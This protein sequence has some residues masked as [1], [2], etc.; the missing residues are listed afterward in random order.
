MDYSLLLFLCS[1]LFG[2]FNTATP[3]LCSI[4]LSFSP[5]SLEDDSPLNDNFSFRTEDLKDSHTSKK[6]SEI[7]EPDSSGDPELTPG[8]LNS[9]SESPELTASVETVVLDE[10]PDDDFISEKDYSDALDSEDDQTDSLSKDAVDDD[11]GQHGRLF[12]KLSTEYSDDFKKSTEEGIDMDS[13]KTYTVRSVL[14][15]DSLLV[16]TTPSGCSLLDFTGEDD[17]F[18]V[19]EFNFKTSE[20]EECSKLTEDIIREMNE[21]LARDLVAHR[22][23][24][25]TPQTKMVEIS[26]RDPMRN[27]QLNIKETQAV[28]TASDRLNSENSPDPS[29]PRFGDES[30]ITEEDRREALLLL[31]RTLDFDYYPTDSDSVYVMSFSLNDRDTLDSNREQL[32]NQFYQLFNTPVDQSVNEEESSA[33]T[34][35]KESTSTEDKMNFESI[36]KNLSSY[37]E[38]KLEKL[39]DEMKAFLETDEGKKAVE[40]FQNEMA[41]KLKE[42]E[43]LYKEESELGKK[44]LGDLSKHGVENVQCSKLT[45]ED[46]ANYSKC[47]VLS[48]EG[49][50]V[51]FVSPKTIYWLMQ[52]KCGLQS[53]AALL[54]IARDLSNIGIISNKHVNNL[55]Q[56]FDLNKICNA[57]THSYLS[58][59]SPGLMNP[60]SRSANSNN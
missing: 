52:T 11:E 29:S 48:V 24:Q 17:G 37:S 14:P 28:F 51:C 40:K 43:K 42:V 20:L 35:N 30:D 39:L 41:S 56:S 58:K 1:V 54:S 3:A 5:D 19:V 26:V 9:R 32:L 38:E 34:E 49:K 47:Q 15:V 57:I 12:E 31:S 55:E 25:A 59:L 18:Q 36:F 2:I 23:T 21:Q 13:E 10:S 4:P 6:S 60:N 22:T 16:L 50:D 46:C 45:T 7:T 53:K 44:I 27:R 33:R 8:T